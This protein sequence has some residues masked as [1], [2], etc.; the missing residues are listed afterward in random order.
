[1]TYTCSA[2]GDSYTTPVNPLGHD[3]SVACYSVESSW[4][5]CSRCE[6]TTEE[7]AR[8]YTVIFQSYADDVNVTMSGT[9]AYGSTVTA[10]VL[11]SNCFDLTYNW[12]VVNE[13]LL[14]WTAVA[15]AGLIDLETGDNSITVPG[16]ISVTGVK[17][18]AI[19]MSVKYAENSESS[20]TLL[21]VYVMVNCD[22]GTQ[23]T[24]VFP[25]ESELVISGGK[26]DGVD[27]YLFA[28]DLTAEQLLC[29]D[30]LT[31]SFGEAYKQFDKEIAAL[32]F[33]YSNALNNSVDLDGES[34]QAKELVAAS[35][36]YGAAVQEYFYNNPNYIIT[37]SKPDVTAT[38]AYNTL[39]V[40][41][42][43][44]M[45]GDVPIASFKS[46][47][48]SFGLEYMIRYAYEISL[49]EGATATKVGVI[50]TDADGLL[51]TTAKWDG[52][53]GQW[54][55]T[56]GT[57]TNG[58][59]LSTFDV[60]AT[61]LSDHYA[62]VY[63]EYTDAEGNACYAYS[64]TLK[65]GVKTYLNREIYKSTTA[66]DYETNQKLWKYVNLLNSLLEIAN[67]VEKSGSNV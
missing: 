49:P 9:Y 8:Q 6:D 14:D 7:V 53:T 34:D 64:Q 18:G 10:P 24:A 41:G 40:S 26:V 12:S 19:S 22:A 44:T 58:R 50:I 21:T 11:S 65:Y 33:A 16:E 48:V 38:D 35:L 29:Q 20:G 59:N 31:V 47:R 61:E 52:T 56:H 27:S 42:D 67:L 1:M 55:R 37:E 25:N 46:A 66:A 57:D 30:K 17:S 32:L 13:G 2:C 3:H 51:N 43:A 28:I 60:A 23:V 62:T 5:E 4:H 45:N 15:A 63:V 54:H 36:A 39:T